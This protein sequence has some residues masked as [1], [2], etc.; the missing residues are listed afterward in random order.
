MFDVECRGNCHRALCSF[1]LKH[2]DTVRCRE[3]KNLVFIIIRQREK[4]T[5]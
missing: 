1:A 2:T 3:L 4:V 5:T